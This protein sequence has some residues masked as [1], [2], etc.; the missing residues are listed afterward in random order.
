[1]H[2]I[3]KSLET[4]GRIEIGGVGGEVVGTSSWRWSSFFVGLT[5]GGDP[6]VL[7]IC[8]SIGTFLIGELACLK[9]FEAVSILEILSRINIS[10]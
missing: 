4:P 6:D 2:L 9:L 8:V 1:M 7:F 5:V 3:L 10:T